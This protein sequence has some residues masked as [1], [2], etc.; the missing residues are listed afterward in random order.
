MTDAVNPVAHIISRLRPD[1]R[2]EDCPCGHC[3]SAGR[4]LHL[5]RIG[6]AV[7]AA[8]DATRTSFVKF[9]KKQLDELQRDLASLA[10]E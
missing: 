4:L 2:I 3:K 8:D 6:A 5:A 7:V 1:G 10:G 9:D